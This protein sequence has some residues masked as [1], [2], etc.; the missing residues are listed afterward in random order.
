MTR[1]IADHRSPPEA[2]RTKK[3]IELARREGNEGSHPSTQALLRRPRLGGETARRVKEFLRIE[4]GH[5]A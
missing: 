1:H 3:F 2:G 4:R 5:Q